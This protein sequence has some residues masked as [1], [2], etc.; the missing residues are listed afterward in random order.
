MTS[1]RGQGTR[2]LKEPKYGIEESKVDH[3]EYKQLFATSQDYKS[4][5]DKDKYIYFTM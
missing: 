5:G 1:D 4:F 3:A 2:D